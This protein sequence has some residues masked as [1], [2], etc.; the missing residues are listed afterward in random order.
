MRIMGSMKNIFTRDE[1]GNVT[2]KSIF[3]SVFAAILLAVLV[4][5]LPL[6][7]NGCVSKSAHGN[8]GYTVNVITAPDGAKCYVILDPTYRGVGGNCH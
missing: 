6:V 2:M 7:V 3:A 1:D 8:G 5:F 4:A